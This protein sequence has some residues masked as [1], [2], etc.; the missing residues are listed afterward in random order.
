MLKK[1]PINISVIGFDSSH[2]ASIE[3]FI[4]RYVDGYELV[5]EKY[6]DAIVF[7]A[8]QPLSI[9]QL[10]KQY[11]E[12]HGKPGIVVFSGEV[13]WPEMISLVKPYGIAD[14]RTSL[15]S[16]TKQLDVNNTPTQSVSEAQSIVDDFRASFQKGEGVNTEIEARVQRRKDFQQGLMARK[17]RAEQLTAGIQN[18]QNKVKEEP[19]ATVLARQSA[20]VRTKSFE[21]DLLALTKEA[22]VDI[23]SPLLKLDDNKH[24]ANGL[25]LLVHPNVRD[26]QDSC[27]NLPDFDLTMSNH[28]RN[29]FFNSKGQLLD[30][31]LQARRRGLDEQQIQHIKGLPNQRLQYEPQTDVFL[32]TLDYDM[33]LQMAQIRFRFGELLVQTSTEAVH[34]D[35]TECLRFSAV[36]FIWRLASYS[37]KGKLEEGLSLTEKFQ[38]DSTLPSNV[39]VDLP[40]TAAIIKLWQS[41]A[42]SAN[43]LMRKLQVEQRFVFPFM[44]AASSLGWLH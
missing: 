15:V 18:S 27:G 2:Q 30:I 7:N 12:T 38:L 10:E 24:E 22:M 11:Q 14:L 19:L 25:P 23:E 37:S 1:P 16:L 4:S 17:R 44:T 28:R 29:L 21:E 35:E 5:P 3:L 26:V 20:V 31:V 34:H 33:L 32:C 42:M 13:E 9:E 36:P 8:D 43:E 39:I 40:R 41:E 6:A